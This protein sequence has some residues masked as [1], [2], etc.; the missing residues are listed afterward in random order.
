RVSWVRYAGLPDHPHH[1]RAQQLLPRGVGSVFSFGV[2]PAA[3]DT[4][5]GA[6]GPE[7]GRATA[8]RF[9][10]ALQLASHLAN[11]GDAKTLVLHPATTTHQQLTADQLVAAGIPADLIR[12]S[13]GIE[14]LEDI[15]WDLD[16]ALTEATGRARD[17]AVVPAEQEA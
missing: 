11:I 14:D 7:A 5:D 2:A 9:I 16:Q 3:T 12:I 1:A 10:S 4:D 8:S 6:S 17:G 13:V 15:L